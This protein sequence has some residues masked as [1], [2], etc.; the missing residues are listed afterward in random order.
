[1]HKKPT[2]AQRLRYAFDNTLS[3]GPAALI[4]WL[5][6]VTAILIAAAFLLDVIIGGVAPDAGLGP[7]E[8][9]WNIL[10]QAL[11]PNPPG[12]FDSPW[13]F[14]VIMFGVTI[15]SLAMVSILIGLASA[16]IQER[17]E[18]L[19]RGRSHIIEKNHTVILG[20]SEQIFAVVSELIVANANQPRATIA[21]LGD[22]DKVEME[23][24]LRHRIKSAGHTHIVV[25]RGNSTQ[26]ADLDLVS[27]Q[28]SKSIIILPMIEDDLPDAATI[29]TIL[30]L[31]KAPNRRPEPYHIVAVLRRASNQEIAQLVGGDEVELIFSGDVIA[32]IIA[33]TCRQAGLSNVYTELLDF[34]GDE[35][36]F[37]EEP[38]LVGKTLGEALLAYE[39]SAVIGLARRDDVPRLLP[40]L[41]TVIAPGDLIMAISED[42][43][44]VR[45]SGLSAVPLQAEAIATAQARPRH[46]ER[47]LILGWN[48]R[49]GNIIRQLDAYV[50]PHSVLTVAALHESVESEIESLRG[51]LINQ[52]L[53]WKAV[54]FSARP[55]LDQL[56]LQTYDH[57][58]V[59]AY[60]DTLEVQRAD[61]VTL[62]TLLHVRRIA[63]ENHHRYSIVSEILDQRNR[64][65]AESSRADDFIVS[66][67]LVSLLMAQV[68]ENKAL[69]E[70]FNDLFD[71]IGAE[72]FLKP[73][74]DYVQAGTT[75][76]FY[77]VIEA[78]RRRGEVAIG[79]RVSAL[80]ADEAHA[81]GVV[82][83]PAKSQP[84]TFAPND[85]VI[86]LAES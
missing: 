4:L 33:Q 31:V 82:V 76:S 65:L 15:A 10:F 22:K 86:V 20:W 38:A 70:V 75:I 55:V 40:P 83:N 62:L 74:T 53:A 51:E 48:W 12:N 56:E 79:Y 24:E 21:I 29:K 71:P 58:I 84:I 45:L 3:R 73:V 14:L 32:R 54:D 19:R 5:V 46:T 66:D 8:I 63:D 41:E 77:T 25:R 61:A 68:S 9:F 60:S 35:I 39:D 44:T 11:V 18:T 78:A 2:F 52:E 37:Q 72:V 43:D 67:R 6:I 26:H 85:Q 23:E 80:E 49:A 50:A 30:A 17:I 81:Y 64:E 36:Y 1:M 69:N 28:T 57:I 59:L 16:T 42:D 34:E 47:T 27:P 7:R 13:Q